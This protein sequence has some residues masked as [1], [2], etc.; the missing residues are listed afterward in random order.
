[1]NE[2]KCFFDMLGWTGGTI[3]QV[4]EELGVD[5]NDLLY[6]KPIQPLRTDCDYIKGQYAHDT[7]EKTWVR[8]RL[9][10]KYKGNIDFWLG[11][12]RA[13]Y[14]QNVGK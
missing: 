7:C 5:A 11:Y 10:P 8:D 3:H 13:Y 1:M 9:L 6:G 12:K 14:L 2:T 4:A